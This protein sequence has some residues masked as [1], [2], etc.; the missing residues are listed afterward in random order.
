[1]TAK[2]LKRNVGRWRARGK[3]NEAIFTKIAFA[4]FGENHVAINNEI[5]TMLFA[6]EAMKSFLAEKII[7]VGIMNKP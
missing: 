7:I 1:M 6:N 3:V 2:K 5:T 4:Y